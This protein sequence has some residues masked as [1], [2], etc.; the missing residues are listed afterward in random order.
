[1]G[2]KKMFNSEDKILYM[3]KRDIG[4]RSTSFFTSKSVEYTDKQFTQEELTLTF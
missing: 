3:K 4:I 2:Y 1:M